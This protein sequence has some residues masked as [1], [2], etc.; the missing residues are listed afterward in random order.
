[1]RISSIKHTHPDI[2]KIFAVDRI[3]DTVGPHQFYG[4][5]YIHI[6]YCSTLAVLERWTKGFSTAGH[7]SCAETRQPWKFHLLFISRTQIQD[8]RKKAKNIVPFMPS[9]L[10]ELLSP[11]SLPAWPPVNLLWNPDYIGSFPCKLGIPV[12]HQIVCLLN[13]MLTA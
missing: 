2:L 6:N 3:K 7:T 8:P 13:K 1:M 5:L 12:H 9:F 10:R 4:T 11:Y